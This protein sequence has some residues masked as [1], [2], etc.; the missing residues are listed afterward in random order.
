MKTKPMFNTETMELNSSPN[1]M[2]SE[3]IQKLIDNYRN[4]QLNVINTKLGIN[5][6]HS[7]HF[8]LVTLKKFISDI[9]TEVQKNHPEVTEENLGIRLYYAAYPTTESWSIMANTPIEQEY[10]E[11]HTLVMIP[12][13]KKEDENGD[14]LSYDF[15]PLESNEGE[16]MAMASDKKSG[17]SGEVMSQNHGALNPP[18]QVKVEL[19]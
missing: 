5:D 4:N 15:N 2:S 10:A 18:N 6:A 11:R 1:T 16:F 12:T 14:L 7:I 3:L 13:M 8:D 19:F 9:E 17:L